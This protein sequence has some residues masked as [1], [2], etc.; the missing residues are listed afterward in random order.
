M[1]TKNEHCNQ[2][3]T[4]QPHIDSTS[5]FCV[6]G[7]SA[8]TLADFFGFA[9]LIEDI[10]LPSISRQDLRASRSCRKDGA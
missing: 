5:L 9:A 2:L 8:P 10:S 6:G 4:L 7:I 3:P 1:V